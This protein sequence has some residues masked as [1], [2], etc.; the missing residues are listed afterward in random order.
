MDNRS[1]PVI[2]RELLK[3]LSGNQK[4]D[5][6]ISATGVTA[7]S[8]SGRVSKG[9]DRRVIGGYKAS[10][11]GATFNQGSVRR[12]GAEITAN[13]SLGQQQSGPESKQQIK[14]NQNRPSAGFK[15]PSSRSY[16]PYTQ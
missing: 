14:T 11:I 8:F 2:S 16:D 3:R 15:E 5:P 1:R 10:M 9:F 12:V 6:R 7:R 4:A 13:S